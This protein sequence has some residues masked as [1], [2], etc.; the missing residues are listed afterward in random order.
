MSSLLHLVLHSCGVQMGFCVPVS[1]WTARRILNTYAIHVAI[2]DAAIDFARSNA[3]NDKKSNEEEE[4]ENAHRHLRTVL[5]KT[6]NEALVRY[7]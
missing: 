7:E 6:E 2:D 4:L 5:E 3:T 1:P